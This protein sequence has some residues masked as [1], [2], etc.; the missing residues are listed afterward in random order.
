MSHENGSIA[1]TAAGI[2]LAAIIITPIAYV[3][4][5]LIGFLIATIRL[6]ITSAY[7]GVRA[8]VLG[9]L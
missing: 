6:A 2:G 8:W 7:R 4:G 3:L 9:R 5:T 1:G